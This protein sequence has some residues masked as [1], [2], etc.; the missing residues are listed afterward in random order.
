MTVLKSYLMFVTVGL[1]L[2]EA[3]DFSATTELGAFCVNPAGEPGKCIPTRDCE[4]LLHVVGQAIV[5]PKEKL[6]LLNSRC[7]THERRP[8]VCCAGPPPDER[9]ELPSPP[10]CGIQSSSRL[11][12]GQLTQIDDFPWTVLIEYAKPDGS[13]GFHCGGTLISQ[14]H[15][16][17]A[18]HCV[19]S[20]PPGWKVNRVR[21]GEWD[22]S[23]SEDCEHDSCNNPVID[24]NIAKI[25]V[26]DGYD[27][28]GNSF[29]NDIALIQ[30]KEQVNFTDTVQPICLP[31]SELIRSENITGSFSIVAGWGSTPRDSGF[32]KKLQVDLNLRDTQQCSSLLEQRGTGFLHSTQLCAL[33]ERSS[34]E[35]CSA[36]AGGGLVRFF[37]GF[38]YLIGV[39]GLGE[40]KCGWADVPGVYTEVS[41]YVDWI[42]NNR[43]QSCVNPGGKPGTCIP[44]RECPPL[45]AIYRKPIT[46][47]D[48]SRFLANS[49]C[50]EIDRRTL[51]C[52]ETADFS[53]TT[54]TGLPV[55]P[56]C[57][58]QLSDR[59]VGGQITELEEFPW[60]A[61]IQYWRPE[62]FY[63]FYC[64]GALINARY[65]LTAAHCVKFLPQGWQISKVRLGE[66]DLATENDCSN[67]VC[68]PSPIDL[69]LEN[70]IA[71]RDYTG[72][73]TS[74]VNDIALM[75]L[76]QDVPWSSTIRP[77][78]LPVMD[79][80]RN[81]NW[82]GM[83]SFAVGWG[84]TET[85][86][87]S[88]KK[89]KV[90]L[91]V[92]DLTNCL[93]AYS[94]N[95]IYLKPSQM[96]AGG[97]RGKDTCTGD[98]G[99]PL[100]AKV[101]GAWYLIGIVSYGANKCGTPGYPG[102]YTNVAMHMDWI[103]SN[104]Q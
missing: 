37:Y 27:L 88:E 29:S 55:A 25:I 95:G 46:T 19:S 48:E 24:V 7:G 62:G 6:F 10:S 101:K 54:I 58:I 20:L 43:G 11:I 40:Q 93:Q 67:G 80:I 92:R 14:G 53:D 32:S 33:G 103:E 102:I 64:G 98:S 21:L 1:L 18:A 45:L 41:A 94:G 38:Y 35:I 71:H 83:S 2:I 82:V 72:K 69:A 60:S 73:N 70:I 99:G 87:A 57:G 44:F 22:I 16:V 3:F 42:K 28:R 51:V 8:L 36:D 31:L 30:F 75:R 59:I 86:L 13:Y 61:L 23:T 12:G 78:C 17:T 96:C 9:L 39:A 74:H 68:S 52:C 85:A 79:S 97:V 66:W 56:R 104:M 90:E 63:E 50:G 15:I 89:L 5:S 91:N 77:I 47:P 76:E 65:I 4:V 34:R 26:H 81:R 100:M 84:K 49:R